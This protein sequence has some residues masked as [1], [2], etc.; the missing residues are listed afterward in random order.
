MST[1]C[2]TMLILEPNYSNKLLCKREFYEQ[3]IGKEVEKKYL[4]YN[5]SKMLYRKFNEN[6]FEVP[7]K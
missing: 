6:T 1:S 4:S 7:K 2:K 3:K 5:I